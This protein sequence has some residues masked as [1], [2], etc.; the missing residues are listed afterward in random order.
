MAFQSIFQVEGID[1]HLIRLTVPSPFLSR[2]W[3]SITLQ[4]KYCYCPTP[5]PPSLSS[6]ICHSPSSGTQ[7]RWEE[8]SILYCV[9][10]KS[11]STCL[12]T[13]LEWLRQ[14]TG[15]EGNK[16]EGWLEF[17]LVVEKRFREV[18]NLR[19]WQCW[20]WIDTL[21]LDV[22]LLVW[23]GRKSGLENSKKF[24]QSPAID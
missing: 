19:H 20:E 2:L 13:V 9:R 3:V 24:R 14:G 7:K 16:G 5:I 1:D 6:V 15:Y 18:L 4:F 21:S 22:L 8:K 10:P 23:W 12:L 17:L 11:F